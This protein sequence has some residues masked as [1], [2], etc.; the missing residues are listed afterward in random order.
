MQ[1]D[2]ENKTVSIAVS[3]AK[4]SGRVLKSA[5]IKLLEH[6]K[7]PEKHKDVVRHG[8]QSVKQLIGQNQGVSNVDLNDPEIRRFERIAR[9]Y[10]VD[11]AIKRVHGQKHQYQIFF[12]SRDADA[13]TSALSEF[14][15]QKM[16]KSKKPSVLKALKSFQQA[17]ASQLN[18]T[19]EKIKDRGQ[20]L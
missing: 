11:Y 3:T 7:N 19:K 16:T 2:L 15:N 18:K 20:S 8:K 12:K 10:G 14:A 9:S 5:I 4:M 6:Q 13:L 1:E 17:L